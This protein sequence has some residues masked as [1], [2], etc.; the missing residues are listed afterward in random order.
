MLLHFF[1]NIVKAIYVKLINPL[2]CKVFP[3]MSKITQELDKV[4]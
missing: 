1:Y 4:M 3:M 2:V